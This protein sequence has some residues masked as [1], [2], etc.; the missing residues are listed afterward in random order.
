MG[1]YDEMVGKCFVSKNLFL[2]TKPDLKQHVL[3][4][5]IAWHRQEKLAVGLRRVQI[6]LL[7]CFLQ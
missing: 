5:A 2:C 4:S 3:H 1:M 7:V 6:P